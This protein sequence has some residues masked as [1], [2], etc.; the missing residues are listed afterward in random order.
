MNQSNILQSINWKNVMRISF[1][2][3]LLLLVIVGCSYASSSTAQSILNTEVSLNFSNVSLKEAV[4]T[5]QTQT[6]VKFVYSSRVPLTNK[7]SLNVAKT[8]LSAALDQLLEP[9]HISYRVINEQIVLTT[10]KAKITTTE[11]LPQST[12]AIQ[13]IQQSVSGTVKDATTDESLIG[14]SVVVKGTSKGTTTDVDGKYSLQADAKDVLI[15]SFIGYEPQEIAVGDKTSLDVALVASDKALGDVV[16]VGSRFTKPRTDVDRPVAVD[17]INVR[18]LQQANQVDLG[19]AI[20]YSAPSFNAVKFG[21]NDAAPFVDPATLRGMGPDQVLVLVNNKR[22]HK[23]SFVSINDGVGK[24][25]VGTDVNAVPALSLKRV[26]VLRDGAA[27]Q[28]GSDAIAGVVNLELNNASSGGGVSAYYGQGYTTPNL[29]VAGKIAPKLTKDGQSYNIAAN[30]GMKLGQK[31]FLNTTVS[32][33]HSDPYDRSGTYKAAAGFY[34]K[35]A[36][37]DA[38]RVLANGINLDRAVLGS[39]DVTNYGI[40]INAGAPINDKWNMYAF[41]GYTQKK[42]TTFVFTR[43]PSNV[44]RSVLEIFPNGYNPKAPATMND[45]AITVG[46]KG[47]VGNDWNLDLSTS[48]SGNK[49][50]WYAENTT[51]PS[52]GAASPTSF[53]VG[54]TGITQT[55]VNADLSKSFNK[56]SYPNFSVGAGTEFRYETYKLVAGDDASWKPGPLFKTKDVG[57]SGREGFSQKA[58]GDWNRTNVGLYVEA[59]SDITKNFLVGAAVRGE[60]YSDFGSDLSYKLNSRVKIID[61]LAVRGS[62]SRGFRAP[63]M[64]QAHYS[65]YVNISFDN[66]GNSII[67]PIIPATSDLAKLLGIDGLKK[68]ISFDVSGGITSKIGENLVLTADIYQIDVDNRIMLSGQIDVSKIPQFVSAGFPQSANVFVNAID[69]R[70]R[71]FEFV[72]AYNAALNTD[73][74]IG[75]NVGYSSMNTTLRN[76][77][78]TSTGVVVADKTATLYITDGLPKDKL[79]ASLNYNYKQI[80][81]LFRVSRFGKVSDPLATL[82]VKPTDPTAITYQVFSE[83][84]ILDASISYKP[85]KN[86][87]ITLGVNNLTDVYPDLLQAPQTT[88]EVVFSRRTN[89]FG[90]Q[91]RF[92][93]ISANYTF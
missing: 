50:D 63:S 1:L 30:F 89:Q 47:T 17:V 39:A 81:F 80:G 22:R 72:A 71:G 42:V 49:V 62:V 26:E 12:S 6:K 45:H 79:I 4:H 15:F 3:S 74:R 25:Q 33:A 75:V 53:Y 60:N 18:E 51:N 76:T 90:T 68:E 29:D 87:S 70:T 64:V 73:N 44:R 52:Y 88:N 85:I 91:G 32:Y 36:V 48:Q 66:A 2:Q 19:Q 10:E 82:A 37:K 28:Y 14:V 83:K 67:N 92:L 27:A 34:E 8:K 20:T 56:D 38:A 77:R 5:I 13:S 40:F 43:P 31:G 93:N 16:V 7:V 84:T 59:E 58:A 78:K 41:G 11:T 65:N 61:Q 21:I 54:Q 24:G 35:D 23:V 86:L 9:A 57:S 55:L 46:A 69:T